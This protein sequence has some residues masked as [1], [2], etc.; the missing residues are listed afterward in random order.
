[1]AYV[2]QHTGPH[3]PLPATKLQLIGFLL[4]EQ[5]SL[6]VVEIPD[7]DG[8]YPSL[9]PLLTLRDFLLR[10]WTQV[11]Q[12][13]GVFKVCLE[14]QKVFLSFFILHIFVCITCNVVNIYFAAYVLGDF[15]KKYFDCIPQI[16]SDWVTVCLHTH[17]GVARCANEE[18]DGQENIF[19]WYSV[20]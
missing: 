14:R 4:E 17:L 5:C 11:L 16:A 1:M 15:R 18:N 3:I 8:L 12:L 13:T 19:L 10:D 2:E 7:A 9:C 6:P 20:R